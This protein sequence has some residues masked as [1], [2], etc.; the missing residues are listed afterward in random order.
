MQRT[1]FALLAIGLS[2]AL[3]TPTP[4][5][6]QDEDEII[7]TGTRM[8]RAD[9]FEESGGAPGVTV[10]KRGDFLLLGVTIE[11][12]AR[13]LTDRMNEL[14]DTIEAFIKA[15]ETDD[16]IE[17]SI[18][19]SGKT[20]RRLTQANYIQGVSFGG[21]PDTSVARMRVKTAIPNR[22]ENSAILASK[23]SRFVEGIEET[24]RISIST[25]GETS[26]SVVDPYQYRDEVVAKIVDEI[27]AITDA[28]GPEY[29]AIIKGLDR[30]VYWDRKGDIDLAF[31]L[32]YSYEI[33]PNTLHSID[34]IEPD[35]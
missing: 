6:A 19:E 18:I 22:V 3:L 9:S 10:V 12:D 1:F 17:L 8:S 14:S 28:L 25:N 13:E 29:V 32:P 2:L 11:S 24:G 26:V 4:I 7:V 27:N 21:R 15:A 23:L 33:I 35:Y 5:Y 34:Q 16:T 30:Q 20:V 31:S